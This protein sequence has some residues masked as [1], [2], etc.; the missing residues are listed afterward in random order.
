MFSNKNILSIQKD[1]IKIFVLWFEIRVNRSRIYP[2]NKELRINGG[3][4]HTTIF[5]TRLYFYSR[6]EVETLQV[7][8]LASLI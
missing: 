8:K 7:V 4:G 3:G 5:F 1:R 2:F 6:Y